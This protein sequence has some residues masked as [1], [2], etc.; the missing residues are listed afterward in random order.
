MT[1]PAVAIFTL[2]SHGTLQQQH[3]T[4]QYE[5]QG[6][7]LRAES[8][9]IIMNFFISYAMPWVKSRRI[10]RNTKRKKDPSV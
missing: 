6:T 9:Q 8:Q 4:K 3:N 5:S 7:D 1:I 2:L 10:S